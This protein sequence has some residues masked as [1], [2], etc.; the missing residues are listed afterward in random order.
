MNKIINLKT[1]ESENDLTPENESDSSQIKLATLS[2][3]YKEESNLD[4]N[5]SNNLGK[6][7]EN[8][9]FLKLKK[10]LNAKSDFR[11]NYSLIDHKKKLNELI[12]NSV[13]KKS[14]NPNTSSDQIK[15]NGMN[16]IQEIES[17][18]GNNSEKVQIDALFPNIE[19]TTVKTFIDEIRDYCHFSDKLNLKIDNEK[20]YNLIVEMTHNILS[21][22][23][24]KSKQLKNYFTLFSKTRKLYLENNDLFKQFYTD[25][26][27]HFKIVDKK[28]NSLTHDEL[29]QR[30]NFIY[31]ICSNKSY[32]K[33]KLFQE[34]L[35]N[36]TQN[37]LLINML[38]EEKKKEDN[39]TKEKNK[40]KKEH[41][42]KSKK[43]KNPQ[44]EDS[45]KK[46]DEEKKEEEE[47]KEDEDESDKK[48]TENSENINDENSNKIN[49]EK[50]QAYNPCEYI[51]RFK[52]I[53][54][55]IE[56]E[57]DGYLLIYLD[58]YENLF[59]PRTI[60]THQIKDLNKKYNEIINLLFSLHPEYFKDGEIDYSKIKKIK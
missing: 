42:R 20:T 19:G 46:E 12:I 31:V 22:I 21:T 18:F 3:D 40:V 1:S 16:L 43:E 50:Y 45:K 6:S 15:I 7:V 32:S 48:K 60:L 17:I 29:I 44:S 10:C 30:S 39:K 4:L 38:S 14:N 13:L 51:E 2:K 53:L 27:K 23:N 11:G 54:N 41:Q 47:E 58:C 37:K 55:T 35:Y 59:I 52:N 33:T 26:L 8:Y 36:E 34:S 5:D 24:K 25:F 49:N 9:F 28:E 57:N 56:Y